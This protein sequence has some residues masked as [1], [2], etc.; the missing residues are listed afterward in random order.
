MYQ[1]IIA[2]PVLG[3]FT[4]NEYHRSVLKQY[5]EVKN[6]VRIPK[7]CRFSRCRRISLQLCRLAKTAFHWQGTELICSSFETKKRPKQQLR[8]APAGGSLNPAH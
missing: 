3:Q 5:H 4:Q 8:I 2:H 1:K 7:S 6:I